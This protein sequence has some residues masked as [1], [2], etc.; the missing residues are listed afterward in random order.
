MRKFRIRFD[1]TLMLSIVI[2]SIFIGI[3][4]MILG[5]VF[6][7]KFDYFEWMENQSLGLF[8][9]NWF[10]F[11]ALIFL[12]RYVLEMITEYCNSD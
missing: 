8:F 6:G 3:L 12:V 11:I 5:E 10:G 1:F 2:L 7:I 9:L 4:Q